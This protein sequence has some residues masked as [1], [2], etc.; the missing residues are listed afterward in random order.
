VSTSFVL[1]LLLSVA[2]M[3]QT[4][5]TFTPTG[6]MITARAGH[7]ATLLNNGK[8][9]IAGGFFGRGSTNTVLASAELY[10]P[11]T[12]TFTAAGN[13]TT[14]RAAHTATLLADGRV[15]IAGGVSGDRP[16]SAELYDPSTG[17]FS[18]TG[19]MIAVRWGLG[20]GDAS[21][22]ATL[23]NNGKVLI[24]GGWN[25]G[26]LSSL[27]SAELYD[28]STGTF[29]A[30]GDMT[31][32]RAAHT[33]TLLADGRVLI[34]GGRTQGD[35][36][37]SSAELYNPDTGRFSLTLGTT[38]FTTISATA[39]LL[40]NGKVLVTLWTLWSPGNSAAVYDPSTETFTATGNRTTYRSERTATLLPDGTVLICGY[41][42]VIGGRPSADL[43]D[44][45]TG[46]FSATGEMA[47]PRYLHTA[48]LLPDGT[49]LMSGGITDVG[50]SNS[51]VTT[52]EL[53]HPVLSPPE[54]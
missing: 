31:T 8:V 25:D 33:A 43:Y 1:P 53:Y 45:A 27:A 51:M 7:T 34:H 5:G 49:V 54:Q 52:A 36:A 37:V 17:T 46:T 24:A 44:P 4:A 13:M 18:A 6:N 47:T 50:A 23:L 10:D 32:T 40:T 28:P 48:T 16:S 39:S 41:A 9:L 3:A 30:T 19:D 26:F 29:S 22:T 11:S 21:H 42:W 20:L 12:G 15:L 38:I 35:D 2:A 14:T